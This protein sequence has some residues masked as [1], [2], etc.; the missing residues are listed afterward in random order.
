MFDKKLPIFLHFFK[1]FVS[2]I[3]FG[4]TAIYG[5]NPLVLITHSGLHRLDD[6][7]PFPVFYWLIGVI[8]LFIDDLDQ[9]TVHFDS[10]PEFVS[11]VE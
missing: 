4:H 7:V 5:P 1:F 3:E 8:T 9:F 10:L 2:E 11:A 6:R